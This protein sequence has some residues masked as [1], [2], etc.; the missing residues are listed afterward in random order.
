MTGIDKQLGCLQIVTIPGNREVLFLFLK[1]ARKLFQSSPNW[2]FRDHH[3]YYSTIRNIPS[4]TPALPL[5]HK[6]SMSAIL[7][8]K[9]VSN[10]SQCVEQLPP[11]SPLFLRPALQFRSLGTTTSLVNALTATLRA[12]VQLLILAQVIVGSAS[13]LLGRCQWCG[14]Y[15]TPRFGKDFSSLIHNYFSLLA[16]CIALVWE[17]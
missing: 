16:S 9:S 15:N 8:L 1:M 14:G 2:S 7:S 10:H 11:T 12:V 3:W 13:W 4:L 5:H 6:Y 17:S